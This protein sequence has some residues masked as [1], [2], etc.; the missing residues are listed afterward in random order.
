MI[1]NG[2]I[3]VL[4]VEDI[5][6]ILDDFDPDETLKVFAAI[7]TQAQAEVIDETDA[8]SREQVI[9]NLDL[10]RL[11]KILEEIQ[12][13]EFAR[14]W[15]LENKAGQPSFFATRRRERT[16]KVEEVGRTLRRMMSWIDSKEV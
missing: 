6:D 15:L 2:Q 10:N 4:H 5:A 7:G 1:R 3:D 11:K 8:T 13:G 9:E 14:D 16:H 12:S